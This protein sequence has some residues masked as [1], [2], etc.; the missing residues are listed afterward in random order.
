MTRGKV[1]EWKRISLFPNT[2]VA[3]DPERPWN[4]REDLSD[5]VSRA[6]NVPCGI[7]AYFI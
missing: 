6:T 1:K 3:N 4:V 5:C 7:R 2:H